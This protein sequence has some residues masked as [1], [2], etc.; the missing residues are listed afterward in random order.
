MIEIQNLGYWRLW[1]ILLIGGEPFKGMMSEYMRRAARIK[2]LEDANKSCHGELEEATKKNIN[3]FA[4]VS[5]LREI[6]NNLNYEVRRLE[7]E[8]QAVPETFVTRLTK[9]RH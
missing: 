6:N 2:E 1:L 3:L 8:L 4:S 5:E 9:V 7:K